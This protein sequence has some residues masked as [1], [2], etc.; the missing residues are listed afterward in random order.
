LSSTADPF[1]LLIVQVAIGAILGAACLLGGATVAAG[2]ESPFQGDTARF[3]LE[4]PDIAAFIQDVVTKD[5]LPREQVIAALSA[6]KLRPEIAAATDAAAEKVLSWWQY[7]ARFV[8]A[9]R[10]D[11]G[12]QFWRHHKKRLAAIASR[13][14][15]A[16]EYVIAILG[17]ETDYGESTGRNLEIDTLMT[18]AFNYATRGTFFRSELREF[19]LLTRDVGLDPLSTRGSYGGA[20]GAPQF[21]PS[22]Y[23]RFA[24]SRKA[25]HAVN[26]WTDWQAILISIADFLKEH[27]WRKGG[28]VLVD[29]HVGDG[30]DIPVSDGLALDETVATLN[31]RGVK[32]DLVVP[33][34]T[35]AVLIRAALEDA[36]QYR[37]GF[38]N[39][40][41][42]SR[43][44]PRINYAMAVCDL[45]HELRDRNAAVRRAQGDHGDGS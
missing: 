19:L 8:T 5:G 41:V 15:I 35:P 43:Y 40:Y 42:I 28:P 7:R 22:T 30:V 21:M 10:V 38:K 4:R 20:L 16:P 3:D 14:G 34:A 26:L 27:G 29:G 33:G 39:F 2:A 17:V 32:I 31:A 11:A 1:E 24:A 13:Y 18:L 25:R 6:A 9:A 36:V 12:L 44:N 37:V 45:A 23:R